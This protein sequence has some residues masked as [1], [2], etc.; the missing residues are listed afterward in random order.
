MLPCS[1]HNNLLTSQFVLENAL[2]GLVHTFFYNF[3]EEVILNS[4]FPYFSFLFDYFDNFLFSS[5]PTPN[6]N[7]ANFQEQ[8]QTYT[9]APDKENKVST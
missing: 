3:F 5:T 2:V 6:L 4:Y 7:V 8:P 1:F 9:F